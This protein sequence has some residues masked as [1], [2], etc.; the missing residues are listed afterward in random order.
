MQMTLNSSLS[1]QQPKQENII[2]LEYQL[3]QSLNQETIGQKSIDFQKPNTKLGKD[4]EKKVKKDLIKRGYTDIISDISTII[5]FRGNRVCSVDFL[6]TNTE[7]VTEYIEAK[8]G[9][10]GRINSQ[11]KQ[12]SGARRT[13][14][15][16]KA[17][18]NGRLVKRIIPNSIYIVYFSQFPKP[19]SPSDL[20]IQAALEFGDLDEV[21]YLEFYETT[22]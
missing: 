14:N 16:K 8:G 19:G 2:N 9:V 4:Y 21:R 7:G 15:V 3:Q 22:N 10:T 13:D 1:S 18:W 17:L 11:N 5:Y 6:A 12:D 20:M